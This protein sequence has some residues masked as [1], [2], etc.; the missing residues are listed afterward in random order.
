MSKESSIE[1]EERASVWLARR[2]S[3]EW[4]AEDEARFI[5]WLNAS[6]AHRVAFL[7]Q[8]AAWEHAQRLQALRGDMPVGKVPS[9]QDWL[10]SPF[11]ADADLPAPE[12]EP[13]ASVGAAGARTSR[14]RWIGLAAG[15][16]LVLA[17]VVAWQ[18]WPPG[19]AYATPVGGIASIPM[20][21][22]SKV[23]LNTDSRIRID[24]TESERRVELA[25]GE[26]YFEVAKDPARPFIVKVGD[27]RII[28]VGTAFSVRRLEDN[29]RVIVTEGAVRIETDEDRSKRRAK[30]ADASTE[31]GQ[32]RADGGMLVPAGSIARIGDSGLIVRNVA[33]PQVQDDL[34][35]RSGFLVFRDTPL[36]EAI[37]EFNRY[38]EQQIVI[39]DAEV[40]AM[41]FSGR[42]RATHFEPFIRL[43]EGSFPIQAERNGNTITLTAQD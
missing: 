17:A 40:A 28:A 33:L 30:T 39:R 1:I 20:R 43:L 38:N 22:G 14:L 8:E 3:G 21:D 41:R 15:F 42:I 9:P 25:Q 6:T 4:S 27:K 36:A 18:Y 31:G 23:I 35:W 26:A 24:V 16:V 12:R 29:I 34:S 5:E 7:R 32:P 13:D 11:F 2:E 19:S 10:R 37:A